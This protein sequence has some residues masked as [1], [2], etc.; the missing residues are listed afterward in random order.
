MK[1]C[2]AVLLMSTVCVFAGWPALAAAAEKKPSPWEK[3]NVNL[4]VFFATV[5]STA[6][7][8][9]PS[10]GVDFDVEDT[11]GLGSGNNAFRINAAWRFTENRRH[12]VDFDWFSLNR[13]GSTT[14]GR[15]LDINGM[16]FPAGAYVSS[17]LNLDL[18]R[19]S[20]SYSIVQD[21][22][23]DLAVSAGLY[24]APMSLD[25]NASGGF[26]GSVSQSITAPLPVIGLRADF[27]ITPKWF[28]RSKFDV[29]Y[30]SID[31]YTGYISDIQVA[32]EYK[33]FKHVGFGLGIDTMHL[34]VE[35][36]SGTSVP[37]VDFDGKFSFQYAGIY[38]YT[39]LY[40]D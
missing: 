27:A 9:T 36:E 33:A 14:L 1:R 16:T 8:G 28:L 4:G 3:Y 40:F 24:I 12:R 26:T 10:A 29:F 22:R 31:N 13:S 17:K 34:A 11:L 5:D 35:A 23:V 7:V 25:V 19:A 30:V 15:D 6:R 39:K 2:L 37:G 32:G 20:Y 18:Y 21:D 38:A